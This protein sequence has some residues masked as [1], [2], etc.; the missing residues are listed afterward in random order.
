MADPLLI[1][2]GF[3]VDR[4]DG[5][6]G[7]VVTIGGVLV[8]ADQLTGGYLSTTQVDA[9]TATYSANGHVATVKDAANNLSTVVYDPYDRVS[10]VQFPMPTTGASNPGDY[11]GYVYDALNWVISIGENGA[12]SGVGLPASYGYDAL[13][14]RRRSFA[15]G[16]IWWGNT[17]GRE[18]S[19]DAMCRAPG[20]TSRARSSPGRTRTGWRGPATL[21]APIASR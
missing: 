20:R 10:Q 14:R 11:E 5:A 12:T 3:R 4:T 7:K 19:S 2:H 18:A 1:A 13:G 15:T 17:T 6:R 8:A 16:R 9:V 21:T